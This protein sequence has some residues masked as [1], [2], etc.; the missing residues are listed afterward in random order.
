VNIY[1]Y[2]AGALSSPPLDVYQRSGSMAELELVNTRP[3]ALVAGEQSPFFKDIP[4]R[5]LAFHI[6]RNLIYARPE[7]FLAR[8][9]HADGLR[10]LLAGFIGLYNQKA[11]ALGS[12]GETQ[13][14]AQA[15][16]ELPE[17]VVKRV[18]DLTIPAYGEMKTPNTITQY[19]EAADIAALRG[20]LLMA[21]DLEAAARGAGDAVEGVTRMSSQQ[22]S[23]ELIAFAVSEDHFALREQLGL[24]IKG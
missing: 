15:F 3:P 17:A 21:G 22:K 24:A 19:A 23:K 5:L 12:P 18:K 20:G 6:A 1:K 8:V 4:Q 13:N 2:V 11:L 10:D 7:L 9:Y 14:W 16:L